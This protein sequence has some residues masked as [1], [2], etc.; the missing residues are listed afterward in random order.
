MLRFIIGPRFI[1]GKDVSP[2]YARVGPMSYLI[3]DDGIT[4]GG[5]ILVEGEEGQED[6]LLNDPAILAAVD[7]IALAE[8]LT[9]ALLEGN[10]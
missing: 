7:K 5:V 3:H 4:Q 9:A 1:N 2:M 6:A 8:E 10:V